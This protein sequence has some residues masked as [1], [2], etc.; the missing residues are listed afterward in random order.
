MVIRIFDS[1]VLVLKFNAEDIACIKEIAGGIKRPEAPPRHG[2]APAQWSRAQLAQHL[3]D[4]RRETA[5]SLRNVFMLTSDA[6][7]ETGSVSDDDHI[8]V[9]PLPINHPIYRLEEARKHHLNRRRPPFVQESRKTRPGAHRPVL[10]ADANGNLK[11]GA[12]KADLIC[13]AW[14]RND[15]FWTLDVQGKRWIVKAF[16]GGPQGGA[17]YLN[18]LGPEKNKNFGALPVA[19]SGK[20]SSTVAAEENVETSEDEIAASLESVCVIHPNLDIH[21]D[22]DLCDS[23]ILEDDVYFHCELSDPHRDM[24]EISDFDLCQ[25]CFN[26][27]YHCHEDT[28]DPTKRIIRNGRE[29]RLTSTA[30]PHSTSL[31]GHNKRSS[32]VD[33]SELP[34]LVQRLRSNSPLE[35]PEG[36][37]TGEKRRRSLRQQKASKKHFRPTRNS[38]LPPRNPHFP[39]VE[40]SLSPEVQVHTG[41]RVQNAASSPMEHSKT[42]PKHKQNHERAS[43]DSLYDATP[44]PNQQPAGTIS[45]SN[46]RQ[47]VPQPTED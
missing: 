29:M 25:L 35:S 27:G 41:G 40:D 7:L 16:G 21:L 13:H 20:R 37:S 39:V 5:D 44:R 17:R 2:L 38:E 28:H 34:V 24:Y 18:W 31:D 4:R 15:G 46:T 47:E 43:H 3:W 14:D 9:T 30:N 32:N 8:A 1:I 36:E 11:P 12:A 19:F 23:A 45:S 26:H 33:A 6:P 22:C 10:L 42:K